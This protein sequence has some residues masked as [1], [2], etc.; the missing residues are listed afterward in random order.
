[1]RKLFFVLLPVCFLSF[2]TCNDGDIITTE[3]DFDNTFETCGD[4]I[5]YKTIEDPSESLS[6][7]MSDLDFE[8]LFVV[9]N[10]ETITLTSTSNNIYYIT[11]S[12]SSLPSDLFCN[13]TPDVDVNITNSYS[14]SNNTITMTSTLIEDDNDGISA[15]LEDI[16]GNGNYED[17]DTDGD[18]LPNYLDADDD[19]DNVLTKNEKPDPDGDGQIDDAQDTDG[20]GKADYLD[21]DDDGDGVKTRDEEN[22][23]RDQ[24]PANDITNSNVG[25]DYLNPDV[26]TTVAATAYRSHAIY[27]TYVIKLTIFNLDLGIISY[28]E[29]DFGTLDNSS[30]SNTRTIT[31]VFN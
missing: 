23:S 12:N 17:D 31:P 16:N 1:M 10:G 21:D 19:G 28:D 30:T 25:A 13:N 6:I 2:Y 26:A 18:G 24:N 20:D 27:L 9:E 4:L 7:E 11:Y 8:D 14:S 22:D 15:D 3:L 29:L 5:F